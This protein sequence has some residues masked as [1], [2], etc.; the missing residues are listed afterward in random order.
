MHCLN[1]TSILTR[2]LTRLSLRVQ[3]TRAVRGIH[4]HNMSDDHCSRPPTKRVRSDQDHSK[5]E[6]KERESHMQDG[7]S[8]DEDDKGNKHEDEDWQKKPPFS[9]G[10]SWDGWTTKWRSSCWCGK[11]EWEPQV[12][13]DVSSDSS[14]IRVRLGPQAGQVLPLRGLPATSRWVNAYI[15]L[16]L[17]QSQ[18]LSSLSSLCMT[19]SPGAPCQMAAVFD[20]PS[21]RLDSTPEWLGF[22]S[23]H[24]EVHPLSSTPTP[25][26]RKTSCR[27]CGSPLFDEGRNMCIA[28]PPTFE[29]ARSKKELEKFQESNGKE[30]SH[31]KGEEGGKQ[32]G[33]PQAF[34]PK[35]HIF[36]ERRV[37]DVKDGL[38]KW[39]GLNDRSELMGEEERP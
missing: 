11:S 17:P 20:K 3:L 30:A 38:V 16:L 31:G 29:F 7:K 36:Y 34:R 1:H 35:C 4:A 26:P 25:L 8:G 22:L 12:M 13:P 5:A 18:L 27:A 10:E 2:A 23:A 24:G 21:V 39:R 14:R 32:I 6:T 33:L 9:V 19:L 15:R 28:F 37:V